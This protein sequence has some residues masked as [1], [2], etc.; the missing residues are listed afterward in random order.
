MV[1]GLGGRRAVDWLGGR[2]AVFWTGDRGAVDLLRMQG[3][4]TQEQE[5]KGANR[6]KNRPVR[7]GHTHLREEWHKTM[8]G[9]ATGCL[10]EEFFVGVQV[11][12]GCC[13]DE[14]RENI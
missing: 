13:S 6:G 11:A 12:I 9:I 7:K 2:R 10:T 8:N 4:G 14:R 1:G 3:E 5:N